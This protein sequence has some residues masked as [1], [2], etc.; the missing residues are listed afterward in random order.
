MIEYI[1]RHIK[2]AFLARNG[3]GYAGW[4]LFIIYPFIS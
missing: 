3:G 4:D 1:N 2:N